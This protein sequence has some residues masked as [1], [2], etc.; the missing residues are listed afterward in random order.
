MLKRMSELIF[1]S[2][3]SALL[4][5]CG[6]GGGGGTPATDNGAGSGD[7]VDNVAPVISALSPVN[8]ATDVDPTATLSAIFNEDMFASTLDESS[9][10]LSD[11]NGVIAGT[12]SFDAL[13]NVASFAP[14]NQ[15]AL[16]QNYS[17]SLSAAVTDVSG[18]ALPPTSWSFTTRDG[19]WGAPEFIETD[20]A[21]DADSAQ[22]AMN[23]NGYAMAV[24]RQ[25]DGSNHNIM[26]RPYIPGTGWGEV[27]PIEA[28]DANAY[29]PQIVVDANGNAIVVWQQAVRDG[30]TDVIGRFW[31]NRYTPD[32]G[33][34]TAEPIE[35]SMTD[36]MAAQYLQLAVGG[37]GNAIAVWQQQDAR[38]SSIIRANHYTPNDGWGVA[39]RIDRIDNDL[40]PFRGAPKIA[41]DA[42]GNALAVWPQEED[43]YGFGSSN[44]WVNRYTPGSG[45][46]EAQLIETDTGYATNPQV[47]FDT[48]GNALAAWDQSDDNGRFRIL[49]KRYTPEDGWGEVVPIED[50]SQV[51]SYLYQIVVNASGKA[52]VVWIQ[53]ESIW[54]SRYTPDSGWDSTPELI[55]SG[56]VL[57]DLQI[58]I[59]TNDNALAIWAEE[60]SGTD[61]IWAKRYTSSDGWSRAEIFI[62]TDAFNPRIAID[63]NGNA[64]AVWEQSDSPRDNVLT[65][66]FE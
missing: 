22:I 7:A 19:V 33:W 23:A 60:E 54:A 34:D 10:T 3:L 14:T 26:A 46:D 57:S 28:D 42:N 40:F 31:A 36:R 6:G 65:S 9:F 55:V 51:N 2:I 48:N 29:D 24:W 11:S 20:D 25:Y 49:T 44:N 41:M 4:F 32:G 61:K 50:D 39:E 37:N 21:G 62:A 12:V 16:L 1:V 30:G 35:T 27:E 13:T 17:A 18:N 59:D 38:I 64:I 58:V 15:L 43:F 47:A 8:G 45:W 53:D 52:L 66:R 63:A 5:A 56:V